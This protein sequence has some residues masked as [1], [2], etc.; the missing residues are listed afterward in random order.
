LFRS[1]EHAYRPAG[2]EPITATFGERD[3]ALEKKVL[4]DDKVQADLYFPRKCSA[5]NRVIIAHDHSSVQLNVGHVNHLGVYTGAYT[6]FAFCGAVRKMGN[7][8]AAL[9]RLAAQKGLVK[10]LSRF[11]GPDKFKSEKP[12]R[13][14]E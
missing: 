12:A 8:D 10:D 11:A 14:D 1:L 7:C 2:P 9:N 6:A 13:D 3:A 5:T 4:L